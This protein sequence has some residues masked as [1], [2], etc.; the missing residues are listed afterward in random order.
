VKGFGPKSAERILRGIDILRRGSGLHHFHRALE[1][2]E[3]T[4]AALA[5]T[6]LADRVEIAGSLRRRKE[7]VRDVDL[8]AASE[9]PRELSEAF[10]ES[11]EVVETVAAGGTK[12]SVRF[13]DG[14]GADLRVVAPEEFAAALL[15]FTGSEEHNTALRGRA[16]RLDRKLNEYGL[17][18]TDGDARVPAATEEDLYRA[19]GLAFIEPE[20]REN[21]GEIESAERGELPALVRESDLRGLIHVH[22]TESDGRDT[23]EDM[24]GATRAAGY[25]YVAITDHSV[26]AGYAGGLSP[27]RVLRQREDIA[28]LQ[29][30][31]PD[32]TIFHGTEADI[33]ADGSIDFG[34][35]FLEV[36][37]LVV[38]SVHSRFGLSRDEQTRRLIA[39]V[40]NRRVSIL[41]HPTGRLLLSRD[42]IDVDA[43][44]V[45]DAAA[46]SGCAIEIN[47]NPHRLELDWRLC[48]RAVE[49]GVKLS[50]DPD[51]HSIAELGLVRYGVGIARKGWVTRDATLNAMTAE[52]LG[53]WLARRRAGGR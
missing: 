15:Y 23:L 25:G 10:L 22:T 24:V 9:R 41:G 52:E 51:A 34:D 4:R 36:F 7:V 12:T 40:S 3:R 6:G 16:K 42:P 48:R 29:A 49:R 53:R 5:A 31:H 27:E 8:V 44:A 38:A 46:A 26:S 17:F 28:R 19:L 32:F 30:A 20:L 35:E 11:P 33:L 39:A 50:I 45:I 14:L 1:R 21:R 2:A 47:G 13:A 37:D 18:R 43:E